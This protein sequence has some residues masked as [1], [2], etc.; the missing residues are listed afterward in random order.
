MNPAT[1][2][3]RSLHHDMM[4]DWT[5]SVLLRHKPTG[6]IWFGEYDGSL[7][8]LAQGI[9]IAAFGTPLDW[10]YAEIY[11]P[12]KGEEHAPSERRAT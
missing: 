4:E 8:F 1:S 11:P 7:G 3:W 5:N 10:E 9:S 6:Q 12:E 2:E